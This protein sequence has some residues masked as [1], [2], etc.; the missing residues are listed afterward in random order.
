MS[1]WFVYVCLTDTLIGNGVNWFLRLD[2]AKP[3]LSLN[4]PVCS[5]D[6]IPISV[7]EVSPTRLGLPC[8]KT[9]LQLEDWDFGTQVKVIFS[10]RFYAL[11][12][13]SMIYEAPC[14]ARQAGSARSRRWRRRRWRRRQ[15][16]PAAALNEAVVRRTQDSLG[17]VIRKPPL[18]DRLLSKPPFRYLHAVIPEVIRVTGFM[19]G[20]YTDFELKSDNVKE[21]AKQIPVDQLGQK[22]LEKK[23]VSWN[24]K[25]RKQ[26]GALRKYLQNHPQIFQF[27]PDENKVG[28]KAK[29]KLP[30]KSDSRGQDLQSPPQK[31]DVQWNSEKEPTRLRDSSAGCHWFDLND[32]V[33]PIK[34]KDI[35]KQFQGKESAYMLFYRKSPL[36]RAHEARGNARYQI[37]EHLLNEMNAA[38]TELQ[39]KRAEC[40][41][42]NN[43]IDLHLHLSS[44][45]KFHHG[46][47]HPSRTWKESVVDL[48]IDRR[49]TLGELRQ[50]V[51]QMLE[52]WEGDL[53]LSI[54]KPLPAGLHL[55]QILD[56]DELTLDGV[57]LADAPQSSGSRALWAGRPPGLQKCPSVLQNHALS[58]CELSSTESARERVCQSVAGRA[59]RPAADVARKGTVPQSAS[60]TP[61]P[62]YPLSLSVLKR[63]HAV[64]RHIFGNTSLFCRCAADISTLALGTPLQPHLGHCVFAACHYTLS[65]SKR[66]HLVTELFLSL[67]YLWYGL[68]YSSFLRAEIVFGKELYSLP[69]LNI[70]K[71]GGTKVMTGPDHE[72]VVVNI[73]RLAEYNEGG[74]G[75]H[76]TESQHVFSCST[77]LGDLRRALAPSGGIMLKNGSGPDKEG[78]NWEVFREEDMKETVKS[79]G[80]TDGC[81]VL[82][83]DSHDQSFVN[84]SSGNLTAF[85]YDISWL[86]VQNFC[87]T[88]DEEQ[89]VKM[90]ATIETVMSDIKTKAIRELQL[91]E[92]LANDSCLRPVSGNG[93]LLSPG[94]LPEDYTVK[95][96]E[97]K[98]G[99]LLGLCH[100]KAPASTQLLL[101]FTVGSDQNAS[102]EMEIVVEETASVKEC[103]NLMLE[104]SGLSG[105]NWHW[106]RI[107]WCYEAGEASQENATLKELNVC[108]GDTLVITEELPAKGFLKIP[109]WWLK[110][111]SHK[112]H[113]ENAQ[114]QVNGMTCKM[115]ALQVSP[116]GGELDRFLKE[117]IKWFSFFQGGWLLKFL[118]KCFFFQAM[119][120][121]CCPEQIVSLPSFLR[122]WTVD[123]KRPG[124]LL[125]NNKQ[126]LNDYKL[127]ARVEICL[128]ALQKEEHL[129]PQELLLRVQMGIPGERDYYGSTALVWDISKECTT[130]ALRQRVASHYGLPVDKLEIAKYFPERLEWLPI[131]SWTQQMSK[132]KRKKKQESLQSAPYHLKDGDIIGVKIN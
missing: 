90:T 24:K 38:N 22:V 71:V 99:S 23:G 18:R 34:E 104:K 92:E 82:I 67:L 112:K 37:P 120:L 100:G 61:R 115:D 44:C 129:G 60:V 87:R 117:L 118:K 114:D 16:G 49:K 89:H 51:F 75:Q 11:F 8:A 2:G 63:K 107:D 103:L 119:T 21:E 12:L 102:P 94:K 56:G 77:K 101:Y 39:K 70:R 73:L 123:S 54:A 53:I 48:T 105:D 14:A 110:P 17:R 88:D 57:G 58:I 7:R 35:E 26:Y 132:R 6:S 128:E 42:A 41:S 98:M 125:R 81:S 9:W 95:E 27:S 109:V 74:K 45:Y 31:S 1:I 113:G 28:L 43:G 76:F 97:L 33:H 121:P 30:F 91:E 124:K 96:A 72:P 36:K 116:A 130:W 126:R 106:R 69:R 3:S 78:K 93:K 29:H 80:L 13:E 127:G 55:Y 5:E 122:A 32:K 20:L 10:L 4:F 15:R 68:H 50:S 52:S 59:Q 62:K 131:S 25:Y 85:T 46:A 84:V 65:D 108:R 40:D 111:S 79:V 64:S 86:Q 47:L 19:K 83:L 66:K